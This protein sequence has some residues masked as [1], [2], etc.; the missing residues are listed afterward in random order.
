VPIVITYLYDDAAK[1]VSR[2]TGI[3]WAYLQVESRSPRRPAINLLELDWWDRMRVTF[4]VIAC[5]YLLRR[6][7]GD[8]NGGSIPVPGVVDPVPLSAA[9]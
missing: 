6:Y 3:P 1:D 2:I 5:E 8:D 9:S 7:F 4:T